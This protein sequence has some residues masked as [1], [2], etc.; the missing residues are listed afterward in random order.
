MR[1]IPHLEN[2]LNKLANLV[3]SEDVED[4]YLKLTSLNL[5]PE[6]LADSEHEL[7]THMVNERNRLFNCADFSFEDWF[8]VSDFLGYLTDDILV[9]VDRASMQTSL[10]TRAPFLH[11]EI[12]N[13]SR[14][15]PLSM[16]LRGN[17]GKWIVREV[18]D[19]YIPHTLFE[20]PKHGFGVPLGELLRTDLHD[21]AENLIFESIKFNDCPNFKKYILRN[22]QQH[23][24]CSSDLSH[25]IWPILM[26]ESWREEWT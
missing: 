9:K 18:L 22:W 2:K 19:N 15:I 20:R 26:F 6:L 11:S 25:S 4:L 3:E 17:K 16:K 24:A 7:E 13:F 8:M 5:H 21:W 14:K 12:I 23:I 1:D 10:E